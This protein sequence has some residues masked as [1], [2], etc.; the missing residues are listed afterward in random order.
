MR[1]LYHFGIPSAYRSVM[2]FGCALS[3]VNTKFN[4]IPRRSLHFQSN[5]GNLSTRYVIEP[6]FPYYLNTYTY[7]KYIVQ[8][9]IFLIR[10]LIQRGF[11]KR[12]II[13]YPYCRKN[14]LF[15]LLQV[16]GSTKTNLLD[17]FLT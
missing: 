15:G 14:I 13:N 6:Y 17:T 7:I 16:G 9:L 5:N 2:Q 10:F 11:H 12:T 3:R 8:S 1:Y 4:S